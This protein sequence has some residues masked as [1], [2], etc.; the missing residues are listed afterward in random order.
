M[1]TT[2]ESV[3]YMVMIISSTTKER[4]KASVHNA[5]SMTVMTMNGMTKR[6]ADE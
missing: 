5:R 2:V 4:L 3:P 6:K 1:M